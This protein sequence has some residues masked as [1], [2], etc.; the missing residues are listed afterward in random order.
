MTERYDAVERNVGISSYASPATDNPGFAAVVKA[1]Y[2]DFLVHEGMLCTKSKDVAFS[3]ILG[4]GTSRLCYEMANM[5]ER[6][7]SI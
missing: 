4:C 6:I 7:E 2:S 1:R 3:D 5:I